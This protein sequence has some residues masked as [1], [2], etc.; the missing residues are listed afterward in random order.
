MIES[1]PG[2]VT[3]FVMAQQ[4]AVAKLSTMDAGE[5]SELARK[6]WELPPKL[7][8]KVVK[9]DVLFKRGW[10]WPTEGDAAA[11]LE[12]SK[13]MVDGKLIPK[14]LTWAQVRDAFAL[15]SAARCK[16]AWEKTGR[17][18]DTPA[19][20]AKDAKDLR[21]APAWD[22]R[23]A[24]KRSRPDMTDVGFIGLGMM[25][26][27]MAKNLL[28]KGHSLTVLDMNAASMRALVDAARRQRPRRARSPR[29][30]TSSSRCCP[31]RPTSSA[32]RSA[33]TASSR[34]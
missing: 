19:F 33:G 12:T 16:A 25:G 28:K 14:P 8:A 5:V 7:G 13:Y 34:D 3:A 11:L 15:A 2:V 26:S 1:D 29:R 9:D 17:K 30:A 4:D 22:L 20:E 10:C 23:S 6:Y 21:G 32:W 31:T 27:P 18:P 24:W